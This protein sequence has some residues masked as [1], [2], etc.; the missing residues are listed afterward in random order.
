LSVVQ[1]SGLSRVLREL[2]N[3][4]ISHAMASQVEIHAQLE[5]GQL[6]LQIA[7]DGIGRSPEDWSHGLGLGGVR[8]RVKLLGGQVHWRERHGGGIQ[9]E[10]QVPFG[11]TRP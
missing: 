3:N 2:G 4:I 11:E 7:D 9:C 10:V 1:W 5:R 6:T 8:K